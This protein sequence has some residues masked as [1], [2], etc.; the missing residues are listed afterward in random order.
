M[1]DYAERAGGISTLSFTQFRKV[2]ADIL[3]LGRLKVLRFYMLGEPFLHNELPDFIGYAKAQN[4]AE[5]VEVTSNATALTSK[6]SQR[7]LD[8]GLDYLRLSIYAI[9]PVRHKSITQSDIAPMAIRKNVQILYQMRNSAGLK[10][11][12]IYAKMIDPFD[13][14]EERRFVEE[15]HDITD[16]V[17]IEQPMNWDDPDGVDFLENVYG[18][19]VKREK[20]FQY[21]KEVCTFPFYTLVIHSSGD[22]SVCCVDWEKKTVCG[23]I[24]RETLKEIWTGAKLLAFQRMQIE[25]RKHENEACRNCTFLYTTPDNIDEITR[26]DA[27]Y[28]KAEGAKAQ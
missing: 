21:K 12:L 8:S 19:H 27:L 23:N 17:A 7:I 2:C 10:K 24:F 22:V 11:P 3:D 9:D 28:P 1:E 26:L 5:R 6:N 13:P 14:E 16:E 15:Y 20:L 4:V 25:R 18:S